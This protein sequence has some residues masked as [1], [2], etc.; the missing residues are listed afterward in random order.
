VKRGWL[1]AFEGVDGSGKTTQ[2][3]RLA[4]ALRARGLDVVATREPTDGRFGQR[5]RAMAISGEAPP[6]DEELR[7]FVEDRR[8]HVKETIAPA[9]E[10]GA[11]ILTD[12][13]FLSTVAYQGARGHDPAELLAQSEAEFPP[14]DLVL[15][16][17]IPPAG[18]LERVRRRGA[19]EPAFEQ[20]EYLEEVAAI[21]RS[22]ERDYVER[23]DAAADPDAVSAEVWRIVT[24][25][26][27][28]PGGS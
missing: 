5:I 7:W 18:G 9:L 13:Y 17:E 14:P 8:E 11:V 21:F 27:G 22:V 19:S 10:R 2:V 16:L 28:L 25:R 3:A 1:I 12:R 23:V 24:E 20:R 15:L 6:P 4:E 26:L